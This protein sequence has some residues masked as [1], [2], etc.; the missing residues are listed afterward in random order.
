[1]APDFV[2][3]L[4]GCSFSFESAL[5]QAGIPLRHVVQQR[6]VAMYR[7]NIACT[8]AGRFGG[9]MVV[10]MRPIR[11]RD[12]AKVV[13][14]CARFPQAHG[15]PV[16]V[17]NPRAL[18]IADLMRPDYGDAVEILDD[19]VPVFWGCGVTPQWVAQRSGLAAVHHARAR[20]DV[21]HRP[22]GMTAMTTQAPLAP[23]RWQ[24]WIDRGG[25]FT[26]IVAQ[27][28]RRQRS[29]RTSCCRRTPSSTATPP[30]PASATCSACSAGEPIT[31]ALVECVKMGTT[32]A[33]N[34]LLERK[35]EQTLL[36]ITRGF[37]DALRIA[38]QDRPRLFDRHIVLPELLYAQVIEADERVGAHGEVLRAA[39]RRA[40][41]APSCRRAF[42]AGLRSVAIVLHARLPLHAARGRGRA[43]SRARSASRR[44]ARRTTTSPLM[45]LVQPRRHHRRRRLPVA[46]PAP[47]RR[48]GGR[49]D[50][51]RASCS[52]CSPSAA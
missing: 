29:S 20:Q 43:R 6:N 9:E 11:S 46:D 15:A 5:A 45:K 49:R 1:M 24:F 13:E 2:S 10:S 50:A 35:G 17:G 18:G 16:H 26:D 19:E 39:R 40:R 37:R 52:S 48:A 47:L 44:S 34:A 27:A 7:T 23:S 42:D 38:Y 12:V 36:V 33:T 4:I 8:P 22:E 25:T 14:I 31:P 32:V 51:R 30:S 3:F 21:R 28:A 41:C